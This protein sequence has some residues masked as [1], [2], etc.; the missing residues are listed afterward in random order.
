MLERSSPQSLAP[1]VLHASGERQG[2]RVDG[3]RGRVPQEEEPQGEQP[4]DEVR[5]I[6]LLAIS[7]YSDPGLGPHRISITRTNDHKKRVMFPVL[8]RA[9]HKQSRREVS[10]IA[11]IN[12]PNII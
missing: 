3:G 4:V 11:S 2:R 9:R 7:H 6:L 12:I 1:Q 5:Q 8:S 10:I